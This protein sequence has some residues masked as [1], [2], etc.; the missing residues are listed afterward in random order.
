M[1]LR[2]FTADPK[3][4]SRI[5]A[6]QATDVEAVAR[7]HLAAMGNSTWAQLGERF[8]QC[9]YTVLIDDERFIGFVYQEDMN[10]R[11]FIAGSQ[12]TEAMMNACFKRAWPVLGLAAFPKALQPKVL[13]KLI[14]TRRYND[15]SGADQYPE[16]LFCSFEPNLRGKRVS[17]HINKVLFDDLYARGHKHVKVTTEVDNE[18]AN[19]QLTSWGFEDSERFTFYGKQM[20][21][22]VLDLEACERVEPISRHPAV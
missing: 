13:S 14:G 6:M 2:P 11:G 19:R 5:R 12:N 1:S 10:I 15:A 22:Y 16:S 9:L 8:L 20:V 21:K 4:M 17:G 7:L 3:V 18:A